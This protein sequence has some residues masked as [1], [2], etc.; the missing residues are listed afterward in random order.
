M[1]EA[2]MGI[3]GANEDT[4]LVSSHHNTKKLVFAKF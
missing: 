2:L 3:Y 4:Y 1:V